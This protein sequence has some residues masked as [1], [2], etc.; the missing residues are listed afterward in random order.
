M[1]PCDLRLKKAKSDSI[2]RD[3]PSNFCG[4]ATLEAVEGLSAA[5]LGAGP[6]GFPEGHSDEI[7][8]LFGSG[9]TFLFALPMDEER[10]C[11]PLL[12]IR[13]RWKSLSS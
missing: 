10:G 9:G 8:E 12:L 13:T 7:C 2:G 5:V 1:H 3:A 11:K 4:V 6:A